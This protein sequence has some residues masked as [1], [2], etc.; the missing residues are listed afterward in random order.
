MATKAP[1]KRKLTP[2]QAT[3]RDIY[4]REKPG[5]SLPQAKQV[6]G[7]LTGGPMVVIQ[8]WSLAITVTAML[9]EAGGQITGG[10]G[11]WQQANV[12]RSDPLTQ[13]TGRNL[14]T[15]DLAIVLDGWSKNRSVEGDITKLEALATRRPATLTPPV[16]RLIG[17]VPRPGLKWVINGMDYGDYLRNGKTG[18]R[19]R[20]AFVLHLMEYV[21]D[22]TLIA[23]PKAAAQPTQKR[24]YKVKR[25]DD[26]KKLATKF[27]GK[28]SHWQDIAK[29]N[30]GLRGWKIPASF[31]GKTILIPPP[32][33]KK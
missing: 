20:Q 31:I 10:Y 14:I 27:L 24:K 2:A 29:L 8:A 13:W 5:Q 12:P 33:Q 26:L 9:G 3:A 21:E 23:L 7:H 22:T 4:P 18:A 16:I 11:A 25:G 15:Q 30:K 19:I 28:S 32:N 1:P 6:K 17:G